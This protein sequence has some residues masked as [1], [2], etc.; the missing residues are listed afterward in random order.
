M[1]VKISR[2]PSRKKTTISSDGTTPMKMYDRISFRRTRHSS[3]RFISTNSRHTKTDDGNDQADRRGAAEDRDD[4]R[5]LAGQ[6][7]QRHD[8][9]EQGGD[10]EEAARPGGQAGG[11]AP[12]TAFPSQA[13]G[14]RRPG[15]ARSDTR[16][17]LI[18]LESDD[19]RAA[20]VHLSLVTRGPALGSD[21]SE[22]VK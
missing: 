8:Q 12:S 15:S 9:L 11:R 18:S 3:C 6:T 1:F 20:P 21:H 22:L 4:L 7:D 19:S 13:A 5:Q 10:N 16:G 14:G 2:P 17:V